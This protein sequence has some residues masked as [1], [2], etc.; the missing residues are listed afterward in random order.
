[1]AAFSRPSLTSTA[2]NREEDAR[3]TFPKKGIENS[4]IG[5]D[6]LF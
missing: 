4:I 6:G 5:N 2:E 3:L 1:M